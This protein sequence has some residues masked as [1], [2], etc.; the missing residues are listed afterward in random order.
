MRAV[1]RKPFFL[2]GL[3]ALGIV[4]IGPAIVIHV[5][6]LGVMGIAGLWIVSKRLDRLL[7]K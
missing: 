7:L 5:A 1:G 2:A 6:Y 3:I 4:C